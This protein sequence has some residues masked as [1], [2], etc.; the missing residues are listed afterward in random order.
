MRQVSQVSHR[1]Q[2]SN[3]LELW[4]QLVVQS[5]QRCSLLAVLQP[6][7]IKPYKSRYYFNNKRYGQTY[8]LENSPYFNAINMPNNTASIHPV[9]VCL[10]PYFF[11]FL[12]WSWYQISLIHAHTGCRQLFY[13]CRLD[14]LFSPPHLR[15]HLADRHQTLPRIR[16]W[17][18]FTKFGQKF[19]WSLPP[20]FG[21]VKT[22]KFWRDFGQHDCQYLQNATR[23]RQ[24]ENG[25][26][27][28]GY[29]QS[30]TQANLIRCTFIH[31]WR[32]I[33]PEFS[34]TQRATIRLGIAMHLV[35]FV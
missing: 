4:S 3:Y 27:N 15:G 7:S 12:I 30:P 23:H 22:S 16:W 35:V 17:P 18:R 25:V 34:P 14:R 2:F 9:L 26:A 11:I 20:K 13:R 32:K 21:G 24:S 19:G 31:K 28:Y 1:Y 33:G 10:R 29:S 6:L 8:A 5:S